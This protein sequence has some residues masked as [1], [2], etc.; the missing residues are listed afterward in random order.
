MAEVEYVVTG[1][2]PLA[3]RRYVGDRCPNKKPWRW[4]RA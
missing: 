2:T 1:K 3:E 4:D